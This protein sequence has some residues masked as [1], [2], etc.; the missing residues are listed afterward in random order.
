MRQEKDAIYQ[1]ITS[2]YPEIFTLYEID[3]E[4]LYDNGDW[5]GAR[6]SFKDDTSLQRDSVRLVVKREG[7]W[8]MQGAP[9]ITISKVD[10]PGA[11]TRLLEDINRPSQAD[12]RRYSG[13]P[14][15]RSSYQTE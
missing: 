11:P 14:A 9:R 5:Y 12:E 7:E 8:K 4:A 10:Y 13:N 6:L 1:A 15:P 2:K 3:H